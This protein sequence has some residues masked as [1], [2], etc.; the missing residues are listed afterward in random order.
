M[1][2]IN[3]ICSLIIQLFQILI[4]GL[5][6]IFMKRNWF[7]RPI[8]WLGFSFATL[9][10][11]LIPILIF[12]FAMA[13]LGIEFNHYLGDNL[14][15]FLLIGLFL[16]FMKPVYN[17]IEIVEL[18]SFD[19][20]EPI[21]EI[22]KAIGYLFSFFYFI[23]FVV[24]SGTEIPF[25][26]DYEIKLKGLFILSCLIILPV[27]YFIGRSQSEIIK[28]TLNKKSN[29]LIAFENTLKEGNDDSVKDFYYKKARELGHTEKEIKLFW[30]NFN[31]SKNDNRF[32]K[33]LASVRAKY[34]K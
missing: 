25:L 7:T 21:A 16:L 4:V 8:F 11:T 3:S 33:N 23:Y 15:L 34:V 18:V 14:Q 26:N 2:L 13:I 1:K 5:V 30:D 9:C 29:E 20:I 28:N 19:F 27:E 10:V 22:P 6:I 17:S 24:D 32:L 12:M 31:K